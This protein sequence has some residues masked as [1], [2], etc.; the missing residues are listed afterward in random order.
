MRAH[1]VMIGIAGLSLAATSVAEPA[2]APV[3][4]ASQPTN[5][6]AEVVVASA[7]EVPAVASKPAE[8]TGTPTAKK[9]RRARVI[10]CRCG[11]EAPSDD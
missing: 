4:K 5:P 7:D 3:Q 1:L 11:G 2:K 9:P 8:T 10:S 6:A